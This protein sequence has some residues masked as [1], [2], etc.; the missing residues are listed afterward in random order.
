MIVSTF[1]I[2]VSGST[3]LFPEKVAEEEH[4]AGVSHGQVEGPVRE[5]P[6][7]RWTPLLIKPRS[8]SVG[9]ERS[10]DLE[11]AAIADAPP[12]PPALGVS[13]A[14]LE[15]RADPQTEDAASQVTRVAEAFGVPG[16]KAPAEASPPAPAPP[17]AAPKSGAQTE[18][19]LAAALDFLHD[20]RTQTQA[21]TPRPR[22]AHGAQPGA[23]VAV[24]A[25]APPV[26]RGEAPGASSRPA[27]AG[28]LATDIS[29]YS[30]SFIIRWIAFA[31]IILA[32]ASSCVMIIDYIRPGDS[33]VDPPIGRGVTVLTT[34]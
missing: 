22:A 8:V 16:V 30:P 13:A 25:P 1:A 15:A 24:A 17:E 21:T 27:K 34:A 31:L 14:E 7:K 10:L 18:A 20:A 5:G 2:L 9:L 12:P 6:A 32:T 29:T 28:V 26:V 3:V 11:Q 4:Q 33:R 23:P 19:E